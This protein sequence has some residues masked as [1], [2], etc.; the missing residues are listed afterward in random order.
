[1]VFESLKF[2]MPTNA[3]K[4]R[5]DRLPCDLRY[6]VVKFGINQTLLPGLLNILYFLYVLNDV[7]KSYFVHNNFV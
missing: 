3:S 4:F 2:D 6:V 1:M 7:S 5:L